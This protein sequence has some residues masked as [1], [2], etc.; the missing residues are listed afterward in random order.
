VL[1]NEEIDDLVTDNRYVLD[2][3]FA[4]LMKWE[5]RVGISIVKLRC[6]YQDA[7]IAFDFEY[8]E[9][10]HFSIITL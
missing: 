7:G 8:F 5:V 6:A 4:I 1:R 9:Q 3:K 2:L 10:V